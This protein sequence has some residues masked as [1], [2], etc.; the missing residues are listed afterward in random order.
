MLPKISNTDSKAK[1]TGNDGHD[2]L[3][4]SQQNFL[5]LSIV[6]EGAE[7]LVMGDLMR[8]NILEYKAPRVPKTAA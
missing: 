4:K 5:R 3:E 1:T 6:S 7:Y 8:R 2:G